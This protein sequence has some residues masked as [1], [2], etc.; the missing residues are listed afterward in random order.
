MTGPDRYLYLIA[1]STK[2]NRKNGFR[3]LTGAELPD[4]AGSRAVVLSADGPSRV[5][6]LSGS[7][8][9]LR[10]DGTDCVPVFFIG[11]SERLARHV[12]NSLEGGWDG[13]IDQGN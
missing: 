10:V 7:S 11:V 6:W 12:K 1:N 9:D 5:A 3:R 4:A 8:I 2:F 13:I